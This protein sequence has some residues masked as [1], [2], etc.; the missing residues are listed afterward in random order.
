MKKI[1]WILGI[2]VILFILGIF[3]LQ[4]DSTTTSE[5]IKETPKDKEIEPLANPIP[6][7]E[8]EKDTFLVTRV[9]DGDTIEIETGE[10]VRLT[11]I[12]T[13]ETYE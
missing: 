10:R 6:L 2:V 11:C 8:P 1:Y 5:I 12:D 9:I 4:N 13:P 3:L 7:E